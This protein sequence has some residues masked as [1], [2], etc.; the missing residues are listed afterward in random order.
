MSTTAQEKKESIIA[1]LDAIITMQFL[2]YRHGGLDIVVAFA[3]PF[4]VIDRQGGS[5]R[6]GSAT[7]CIL[8]DLAI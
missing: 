3:E 2:G 6:P 1:D 5:G 4:V 7:P 8:E